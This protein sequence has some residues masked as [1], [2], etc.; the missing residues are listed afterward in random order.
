MK[1]RVI[2]DVTR[3]EEETIEAE[4]FSDAESMWLNEGLDGRLLS[5]TDEDGVEVYFG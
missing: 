5:I 1:Y 4:S 2:Y 3:Y